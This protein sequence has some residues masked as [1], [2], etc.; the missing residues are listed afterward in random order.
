MKNLLIPTVIFFGI[1]VIFSANVAAQGCCKKEKSS[2]NKTA[3]S[4]V[5]TNAVTGKVKDSLKV[6]G[7]CGMCKTR[8]ENTAKNVK[9]VTNANWN[10]S[11]SILVYS[12]EGTVKKD[13]VSN[14]LLKVGHDTELGKAPD[15]IYNKLPGCCKYR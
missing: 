4:N 13:D 14:A 5:Q 9:G 3:K 8:I 7:K 1:A 2:C 12:F 6:S 15:N 10:E 11:T